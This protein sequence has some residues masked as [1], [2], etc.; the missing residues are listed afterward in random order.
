V[1]E[2]SVNKASLSLSL[3]AICEGNLE[4]GFFTG[5]TECYVEGHVFP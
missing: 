3:E 2:G 4:G 5:G 1:K